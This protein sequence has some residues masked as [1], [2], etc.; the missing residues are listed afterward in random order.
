MLLWPWVIA[1]LTQIGIEP[2]NQKAEQQQAQSEVE[3]TE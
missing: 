1:P 2:Q 3:Q